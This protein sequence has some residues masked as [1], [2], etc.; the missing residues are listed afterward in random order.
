M[1]RRWKSFWNQFHKG[2]L[3]R[4]I[5]IGVTTL[6]M[7]QRLSYFGMYKIVVRDIMIKRNIFTRFQLFQLW[8]Q[9]PL[10]KWTPD[11]RPCFGVLVWLRAVCTGYLA[12]Q[13]IDRII[14]VNV[15]MCQNVSSATVYTIYIKEQLNHNYGALWNT[16]S[17]VVTLLDIIVALLKF[18]S[19]AIDWFGGVIPTGKHSRG[20]ELIQ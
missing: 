1:S 11:N 13:F 17:I 20:D 4:P 18:P 5:M 6:H 7:L 16:K 15:S 14:C 10:V 12:Y 9:K 19:H 8:S 3:T 2:I